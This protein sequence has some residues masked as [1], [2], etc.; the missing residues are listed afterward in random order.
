VDTG[1]RKR[2]CSTNKPERDDDSKKSHRALGAAALVLNVADIRHCALRR[3][4]HV[5]RHGRANLPESCPKK[6]GDVPKSPFQPWATL[7]PSAGTIAL[8]IE[9]SD[10]GDVSTRSPACPRAAPPPMTGATIMGALRDVVLCPDGVPSLDHRPDGCD[11]PYRGVIHHGTRKDSSI[12]LRCHV[13][14]STE[15]EP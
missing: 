10:A 15:H 14:T 12:D 4:P 3:A 6:S 9:R 1:F 7:V 13:E 5:S 8:Q 2:S 11:L